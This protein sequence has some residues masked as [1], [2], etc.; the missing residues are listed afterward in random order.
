MRKKQLTLKKAFLQLE[1]ASKDR[2]EYPIPT[3]E[4]ERVLIQAAQEGNEEAKK[5]LVFGNRGLV[6]NP[7]KKFFPFLPLG[8]N[9]DEELMRAAES[10]LIYALKKFDLEKENR[11][12]AYASHWVR[13]AVSE[14]LRKRHLIAVSGRLLNQRSQVRYFSREFLKNSG[15]LPI[16][17]E[18][19]QLTGLTKERI[20]EILDPATMI[21]V[22]SINTPLWPDDEKRGE[23]LDAIG[24]DS[25]LF[26]NASFQELREK[27]AEALLT[28]SKREKEVVELRFGFGD[29]N[30]Q[31]LE[32]IG[33]KIGLSRERVRQIEEKVKK[34][35]V[36]RLQEFKDWTN[37]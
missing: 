15:R 18:L 17:E 16:I 9:I 27:I 29:D 1:T 20:K 7:V 24:E 3:R 10:G 11:L 12:G 30:D 33:R 5:R 6:I 36:R 37:D 22:V 34:K 19:R 14:Y 25:D 2:E 23:L 35:L 32:E 21:S 8:I 26:E 31:T 13:Q 4:E 28:L